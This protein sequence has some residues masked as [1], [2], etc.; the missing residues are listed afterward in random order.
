[1]TSSE[2]I[3]RRLLGGVLRNIPIPRPQ[4][5]GFPTAQ[6]VDR[7]RFA[8][9][10]ALPLAA[11]QYVM[12]FTPR[13][14]SSWISDIATRTRRLGILGESFNPNFLPAMTR[15][16]NATS[17]NEYC[18]IAMRRR[19]RGDVFCFQITH[20]QLTAV[21]ASEDDFLARF[22]SSDS[23]WLI[24]EDIV[25]QAISLY[26]MAV[27]DL[28]HSP[29]ATPRQIRD[30][31]ARF[32]YDGPRIRHWLNHI[33]AAE[34]ATETMINRAGLKPLRMSYERNTALKPSHLLNVMGRH[35]GLP[36]MRLKPVRSPHTKIATPSNT[37][38][39]DRFRHE[40]RDFLKRVEAARAPMLEQL[41]YYGPRYGPRQ[42]P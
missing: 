4:W 9:D 11:K 13:S 10:M 8:A 5:S 25:L 3:L 20:H 32:S 18:N 17:L 28:A 6:E 23:F 15:A 35:I 19:V 33:L 34:Q 21:F 37:E 38:F 36:T 27:T 26:R 41:S 7:D 29:N 39:A 2:P 22:P 1:M 16:M 14:G 30:S 24:R 31:E 12:F 42:K 40:Q